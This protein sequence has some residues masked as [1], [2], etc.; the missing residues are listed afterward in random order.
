MDAKQRLVERPPASFR[1]RW[2]NAA[3]RTRTSTTLLIRV[4]IMKRDDGFVK[5]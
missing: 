4:A 1:S 2:G 3:G 5:A